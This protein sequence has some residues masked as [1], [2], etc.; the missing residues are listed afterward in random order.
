M[1]QYWTHNYGKHLRAAVPNL[2][3][4][5]WATLG[6]AHLAPSPA[7]RCTQG[8]WAT[9]L[10]TA[11]SVVWMHSDGKKQKAYIYIYIFFNIYIYKLPEQNPN[12]MMFYQSTA[13]LGSPSSMWSHVCL[14]HNHS[15]VFYLKS[16]FKS[17]GCLLL[18]GF[19]LLEE[20]LRLHLLFCR[21]IYLQH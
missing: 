20:E 3:A 8:S 9:Q 18:F 1:K 6:T 19:V 7:P 11:T 10:L 21:R 16:S 2:R 4:C 12:K 17:L 15:C 5:I 14:F 13:G